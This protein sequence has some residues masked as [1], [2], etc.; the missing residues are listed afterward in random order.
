MKKLTLI[1]ALTSLLFAS[2][3]KDITVNFPQPPELIVVEGHIEPGGFA[4]VHLT[5]NSSYF[6]PT[7]LAT[8][9]NYVILDATVVV[10]DGQINDTLHLTLNPAIDPYF[11]ISLLYVGTTIIGQPNHSYT[12]KVITKDGKTV[13]ATTTIPSLIPLDSTWFKVEANMDSL[14]FIWG[15]LHDPDTMGNAYRWMV[16]RINH[17]ADGKQKDLGFIADLNSVFDDKVINGKSFDGN[18]NR[19]HL[20][21]D[22]SADNHNIENQMF[23]KGDTIVL[24]FMTIDQA[25]FKFWQTEGIAAQGSGNPFAAPTIIKGNII[26]GL[27]IWGGYGTTY[28]TI[29]AK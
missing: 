24:K 1:L 25:H 11:P 6:A 27:G 3:E 15:H 16:K 4:Y 2:C 10:S 17:Y 8:I 12:L 18:F 22:T 13:T 5:K 19:P 7:D 14:G 28:D 29:I 9:M 26:G 21:H 23:K 20:S